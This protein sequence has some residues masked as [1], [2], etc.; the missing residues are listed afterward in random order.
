MMRCLAAF[1]L[2]GAGLAEL[3]R[4]TA[5]ATDA[6][7]SLHRDT[8]VLRGT[9]DLGVIVERASGSLVV[10]DATRRAA[11]GRIEGLG[12]LSHASHRT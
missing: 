8:A 4:G 10:F 12:D 5:A 9:G 2:L 1:A 6:P 11:I 3:P 7:S